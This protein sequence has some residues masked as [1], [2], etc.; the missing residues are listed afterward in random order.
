MKLLVNIFFALTL[1]VPAFSQSGQ[2]AKSDEQYTKMYHDSK[3]KFARS[4]AEFYAQA[5]NNETLW[6]YFKDRQFALAFLK[7]MEFSQDGL[8]TID[9]RVEDRQFEAAVGKTLGFGQEYWM[10]KGKGYCCEG[11]DCTP[12]SVHSKCLRSCEKSKLTGDPFDPEKVLG[13]GL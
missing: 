9:L 3:F 7:K 8:K 5:K 12:C 4:H 10:S 6:K 11:G 2:S 13:S 1:V